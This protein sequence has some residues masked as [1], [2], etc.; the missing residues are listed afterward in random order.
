MMPAGRVLFVAMLFGKMQA[1]VLPT[2]RVLL[3]CR[4]K[5]PSNNQ[6]RSHWMDDLSEKGSGTESVRL[7]LLCRLSNRAEEVRQKSLRMADLA[8][9]VGVE[10]KSI[11]LRRLFLC[12]V[13][14]SF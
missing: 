4:N 12:V 11:P 9:P 13:V 2:V 1:R 5:C 3:H 14:S 8:L 10:E 6:T 7:P